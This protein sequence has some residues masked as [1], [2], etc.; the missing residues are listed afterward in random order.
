MNCGGCDNEEFRDRLLCCAVHELFCAI[1]NLL[2][3]LPLIGKWYKPYE[4]PDYRPK[5]MK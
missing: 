2:M 3:A 1:R 4:C 5:E